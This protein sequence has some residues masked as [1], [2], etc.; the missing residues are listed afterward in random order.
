MLKQVQ[1]DL[2][3][4]RNELGFDPLKKQVSAVTD[5]TNKKQLQFL[6]DA[7]AVPPV[8]TN[9]NNN[10]DTLTTILQHYYRRPRPQ[11]VVA[12]LYTDYA[13]TSWKRIHSSSHVLRSY[14]NARFQ[15]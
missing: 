2:A 14:N 7:F 8:F 10:D 11:I 15:G 6:I 4:A 5:D 13:P 9:I 12:T 1:Q 3:S